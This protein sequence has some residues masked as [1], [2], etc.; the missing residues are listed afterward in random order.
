MSDL[1]SDLYEGRCLQ[2]RGRRIKAGVRWKEG[3][4]RRMVL[5][6]SFL[7]TLLEIGLC[8]FHLFDLQV[9]RLLRKNTGILTQADPL[10]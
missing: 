9:D 8:L 3:T 2:G 7:D 5:P 6:S 4:P 1:L 10:Y